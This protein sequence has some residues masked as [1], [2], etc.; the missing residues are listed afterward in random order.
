MIL[1]NKGLQKSIKIG[2]LTQSSL[3]SCEI[4]QT[5]AFLLAAHFY[6]TFV[7]NSVH[8]KLSAFS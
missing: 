3:K 5:E 8:C 1:V 4:K 6:L 7:H 2:A